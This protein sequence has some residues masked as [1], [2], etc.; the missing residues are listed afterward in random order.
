MRERRIGLGIGRM[1]LWI[2]AGVVP[3]WASAQ[4]S[5]DPVHLDELVAESVLDYPALLSEW[6]EVEELEARE[7]QVDQPFDPMVS[8]WLM[9]VPYSDLDLT[10]HG[11]T[12]LQIG[13]SQRFYWPGVLDARADETLAM[14]GAREAMIPESVIRIWMEAIAPYYQILGLNRALSVLEEERMVLSMLL[15]AARVRYETGVVPLSDV[16]RASTEINRL[17]QE[18]LAVER[19]LRIA[20]ADING[21]LNRETTTAIDPAIY[22]LET[23]RGA[24]EWLAAAVENRPAFEAFQAQHL[25]VLAQAHSAEASDDPVWNLG[26]SSSIRFQ[27][28]PVG[29]ELWSVSFGINLPFFSNRRVD[30]RLDE[31]SAR[32]SQLD[33]DEEEMIRRLRAEIGSNLEAIDSLAEEIGALDEEL[34]PGIEEIYEGALAHYS[35]SHTD[36]ET[37]MEIQDRILE[38][39]LARVALITQRDMRGEILRA[40][41]ADS[42]VIQSIA[43]SNR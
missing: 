16:L 18:I 30:A 8:V 11:M 12:G 21:L 33:F 32:S 43:W 4:E 15:D 41:T 9:N 24:D 25:L 2:L 34:I 22:D 14:A 37:L 31:L 38:L 10:V 36:I 39:A 26:V 29:A 13:I 35:S 17:D 3:T 23:M 6:A 19:N 5:D 40:I 1:I 7:H 27:D 20:V 42:V 28:D